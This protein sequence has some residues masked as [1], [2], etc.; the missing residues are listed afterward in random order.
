[1]KSVYIFSGLGT[2]DRV[3]KNI[4][5]TGYNKVFIKWDTPYKNESIENYSRRLSQQIKQHRPVLIGLS[6]GGMVAMEVCKYVEVEKVILIASAKTRKDIPFYYKIAG[7]L[8]LHKLVPTAWLRS[9]TRI[10]NWA[11][12]ALSVGDK[13]LLKEIV[14]DTDPVFLRWAI[15]AIVHWKNK[16][17][18]TTVIHIHGRS[19]KILPYM[20][21]K[22]DIAIDKGGHFM[23]VNR[24][25]EVTRVIRSLLVHPS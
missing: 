19:D 13:E 5:L 1:M 20:F 24:S 14:K 21:V 8:Y 16:T 15:N 12:G 10:S 6:F 4:D 9:S 11:F 18:C 7:L 2:D 17:A 23:T 22:A 3:F 25:E